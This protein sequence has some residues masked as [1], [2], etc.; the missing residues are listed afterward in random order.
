MGLQRLD[1]VNVLTT[2]LADMIAWYETMLGMV[3]G[4]RPNFRFPGAWMYVNGNA[5]VH[6]VG[7]ETAP[8]SIEPQIEHFA[9]SATG[10]AE[11][12][13]RL[14][15]QG[16]TYTVDPVPGIPLVQINV[17]DPDGNHIHI[18]FHADENV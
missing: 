3:S 5:V 2:Q 6:L 17:R 10:M 16:V 4:D 8:Q 14:D 15:A 7:V 18:D 11:M 12:R 9:F 1:H 13:A